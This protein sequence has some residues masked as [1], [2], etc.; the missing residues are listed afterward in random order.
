MRRMDL[1]GG[2]HCAA[3]A[4]LLA[5][6]AAPDLMQ[7]AVAEAVLEALVADEAGLQAAGK[8][9]VAVGVQ[10]AVVVVWLLALLAVG[11]TT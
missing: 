11:Q 10:P 3:A 5:A 1:A 2:A 8:V 6:A 7:T 4:P 9:A